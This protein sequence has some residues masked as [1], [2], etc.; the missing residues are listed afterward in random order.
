M[1]H[2][3]TRQHLANKFASAI[4][5]NQPLYLK[6]E[7][8]HIFYSHK[9]RS[10]PIMIDYYASQ[11]YTNFAIS[12]SGNAALSAVKY[13]NHY[14]SNNEKQLHLKIFV[15]LS[16]NKEKFIR[17]Q[18]EIDNNSKISLQQVPNPKQTAFICGKNKDTINLRQSTDD[19]SLIGYEDLAKE[20][21]E[22]PKLSAVFIPSSSGTLA[23]GLAIGFKKVNI[24]PQIHIIQ[25]PS[26]HALLNFSNTTD[27][28]FTTPSL[29]D[30]IVDKV[31]H[32]KESIQM[33]LSEFTGSGWIIDNKEITDT[34]KLLKT[35]ENISLSPNGILGVS[36]LKKAVE[37]GY[38]FNGPVVCVITGK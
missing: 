13:I 8:E 33:I 2:I 31:A 32:R 23:Q 4:N 36:G 3:I 6:R 18:N 27:Q 26:C 38:K 14:N 17:L 15:G 22:I 12:S 28:K 37:N 24:K 30:A 19:L 7:D 21:S 10:I 1:S 11:G 9:G 29:A 34:Q 5:L 35:T 16:I 25:T 20:L